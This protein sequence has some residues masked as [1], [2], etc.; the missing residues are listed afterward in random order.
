MLSDATSYITGGANNGT[1]IGANATYLGFL[2]AN[3]SNFK[4]VTG[5]K[6]SGRLGVYASDGNHTMY[7]IT[8]ENFMNYLGGGLNESK[9]AKIT[10]L[11]Y[12]AP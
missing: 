8:S 1:I 12:V 10:E 4:E 2:V 3:F 5:V 6:V 9:L 7:E 11:T